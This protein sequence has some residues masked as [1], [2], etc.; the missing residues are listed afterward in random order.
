V[1]KVQN[2]AT[3]FQAGAYVGDS[4]ATSSGMMAEAFNQ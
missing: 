4:A 1:A 3:Q 2:L